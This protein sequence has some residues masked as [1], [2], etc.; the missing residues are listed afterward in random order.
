MPDYKK[1]QIYRLWSPHTDKFY[2]GSTCSP[3]AKRL[4]Q[5]RCNCNKY[6]NGNTHYLSSFELFK[7]GIDDVKIE[8]MELCSCNSKAE[9]ERREGQL[10]REHKV[11]LVNFVI[12]S[13]TKKEYYNENKDILIEKKKIYYNENKKMYSEK[14][15]E[16][17]IDNKDKI[18]EYNNK[19]NHEHRDEIKKKRQQYYDNN[20]KK[21][22]EQ[23]RKYRA[24]KKDLLATE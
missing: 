19:Y 12:P 21:I 23:Q 24:A 10:I 18:L 1:G 17:Y 7:L 9:L 16:K 11:N 4:W 14:A 13:R 2:I 20:K 6:L 22:N 15:K 8:L 3:L 5:H